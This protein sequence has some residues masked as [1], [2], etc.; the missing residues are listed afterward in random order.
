MDH[1][2][3]WRPRATTLALF[4]AVGAFTTVSYMG[5][6]HLS[7]VGNDGACLGSRQAAIDGAEAYYTVEGVYPAT[8][9]EMTTGHPADLVLAPT[10]SVVGTTVTN[11]RWTLSMRSGT[12]GAAPSFTCS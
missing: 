5:L 11:G 7:K 1:H 8:F 10:L 4:G 12:R 2:D 6:H 9:V 3:I